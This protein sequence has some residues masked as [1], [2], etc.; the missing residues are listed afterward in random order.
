M[1]KY[2]DIIIGGLFVVAVVGAL[3][4]ISK[5]G[6]SGN[7][8]ATVAPVQAGESKLVAEE[9]FFDFGEISMAAGKVSQSFKIK[10]ASEKTVKVGKL[11]T[12]CMCTEATLDIGGQ[13]FGPYG[14]P[15]HGFSSSINQNIEPGK[16]ASI[17]V[18]FDPA[19]HGPAGV[20]KVERAVYLENDSG[21]AVELKFTAFVK[22]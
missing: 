9:K 11:Y 2:K 22:P 18:V 17:E 3:I 21:R 10:N 20:G 5:P 1:K 7:D 12:S 6:S 14:M 15:G 4:F 19:A 13:K 16:E 8:Q